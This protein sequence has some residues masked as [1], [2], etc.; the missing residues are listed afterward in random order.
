MTPIE[1]SGK[2]HIPKKGGFILVSN[3]VSYLDPVLLGVVCP[4]RLNYMAKQELFRVGWFSKLLSRISVFP[5]KR[6]TADLSAL[7]EALRRLKNGEGLVV[8]PEGSRSS[9]NRGSLKPQPGI[10]FLAT[11]AE[12]P[13]IPSF[14]KGTDLALPKGAKFIRPNRINVYFGE[15]IHIERREPCSYQDIADEIMQC[16]RQ[17]QCA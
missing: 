7:K 8:F 9:I 11:K 2:K 3:H 10:G 16:V 14:I 1:V 15:Q 17:L 12:V 4:R 13:I 5:V 6:N